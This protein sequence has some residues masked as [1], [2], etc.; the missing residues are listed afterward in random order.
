M[1]TFSEE[2]FRC[3][4]LGELIETGVVCPLGGFGWSS[5][6]YSSVFDISIHEEFPITDSIRSNS[7]VLCSNNPDYRKRYPAMD[8]LAYQGEWV[9]GIAIPVYPIG[10]MA[11]YSSIQLELTESMIVFYITIGSLLGLYASRLPTALVAV[12][13]SVKE[14]IDL[15]QVPLSDRQLVIAGLL[16]RGFNNAQIGLEIGYSESLI[17]QETVAIYRK[18]QVTGRKAMQ[19]IK[20]LNLEE[21]SNSEV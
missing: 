16:E 6:E 5:D 2:K 20:T 15:P 21:E 11:L 18:L 14:K 13:L 3:I 19:A 7:V 4:Y 10:G 17:R 12:A 1:N 8:Q 9:S